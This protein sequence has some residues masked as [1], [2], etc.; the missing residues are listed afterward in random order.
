MAV[1]I[2]NYDDIAGY[3]DDFLRVCDFLVRINQETVITPNYLWAR[4]VWQFGPYMSMENLSRIGIAED[5]GIIVGLATYE[6]DIGE[7]YFCIDER[8]EYVTPQLMDYA[9]ENLSRDGNIKI[10]IPDGDLEFQRLA[11]GKGF[12]P[13]TQKSSVAMLDISNQNYTLPDGYRIIDF[14]NK[15]FDV[16]RYYNAIWRGFDNQRQKNERELESDR[17]REGFDAPHL[18]LDLRILVV[19]P[20]GDYASHCGLWHLPNSDY[21]YVE[22]VFT[23][24]EYRKIGLGKAAVLEGVRRCGERGAKRAYVLSSQQFYYSIG[25]Y[26]IHNETWWLCKK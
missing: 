16:E 4:W 2:R 10:T 1:T 26:P 12:T 5:D 8:Y 25:F 15:E 20:N 9:F 6:S 17:K 23:L 7:A 13:T 21:A 14:G 3:S 19:A 11:V 18:D 22:P 24:P